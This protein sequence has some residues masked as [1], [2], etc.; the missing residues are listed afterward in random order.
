[1][2]VCKYEV[3]IRAKGEGGGR[4]KR[5]EGMGKGREGGFSK[6]QRG[7][8]IDRYDPLK[9]FTYIICTH[10]QRERGG[11]GGGRVSIQYADRHTKYLKQ[12]HYIHT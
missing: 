12:Q 2:Y 9:Q 7:R 3:N 1:M 10:T 5:K 8:Y 11:R 6:A 4:G